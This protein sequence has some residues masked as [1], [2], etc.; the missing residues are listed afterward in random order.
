[1]R[2][3]LNNSMLTDNESP[4]CMSGGS[5]VN[6]ND[7]SQKLYHQTGQS[8]HLKRSKEHLE[9]FFLELAIRKLSV[10]H[11]ESLS[12]FFPPTALV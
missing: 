5:R 11:H 3:T 12:V 2:K 9:E 7:P 4:Y 10:D 6:E 8:T 1:M